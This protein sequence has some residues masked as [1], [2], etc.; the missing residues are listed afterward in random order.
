MRGLV[1]T[2]NPTELQALCSMSEQDCRP[3]RET[4]RWLLRKEAAERG[5]L[6]SNAVAL[7]DQ[8]NPDQS[9]PDV[10]AKPNSEVRHE[11]A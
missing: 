3:V 9:N 11:S 5:L 7:P 1:I 4:L 8:S 2:L 6:L 10:S